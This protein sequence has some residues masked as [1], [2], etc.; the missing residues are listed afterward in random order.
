MFEARECKSVVR[1]CYGLMMFVEDSSLWDR[2]LMFPLTAPGGSL[3]LSEGSLLYTG[4]QCYKWAKQCVCGN[5]SLSVCL[6][7]FLKVCVCV[8]WGGGGGQY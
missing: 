1:C 6:S 8:C 2:R 3:G 5:D 7:V 4:M